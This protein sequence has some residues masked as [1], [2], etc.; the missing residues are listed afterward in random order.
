M[1]PKGVLN[2]HLHTGEVKGS[3]HWLQW[4]TSNGMWHPGAHFSVRWTYYVNICTNTYWYVPAVSLSSQKPE[5]SY[6]ITC[7]W[8][9][10]GRLFNLAWDETWTGLPP[11]YAECIWSPNSPEFW[12]TLIQLLCWDR[13][14][15]RFCC[16]LNNF[17]LFRENNQN[18]MK[19]FLCR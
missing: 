3:L 5:R 4:Q 15:G 2:V 7:P 17:I 9:S 19:L 1:P 12:S 6:E 16:L 14:A 11:A 18:L 10:V 13:W 8:Y